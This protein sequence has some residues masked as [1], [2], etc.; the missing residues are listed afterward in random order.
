[1]FKLTITQRCEEILKDSGGNGG[2]AESQQRQEL[3]NPPPLAETADRSGES[4]KS[5]TAGGLASPLATRFS[6]NPPVPPPLQHGKV[7]ELRAYLAKLCRRL[8]MPPEHLLA[9][10]FTAEDLDDIKAGHFPDPTI[11]SEF[12]KTDPTYPFNWQERD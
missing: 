3:H 7:I 1:M 8:P 4:A 2:L 10:Y 9:H 11:L 5:A 12:I 6:A